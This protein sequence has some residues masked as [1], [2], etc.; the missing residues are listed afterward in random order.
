MSQ[1]TSPVQKTTDD[2][3]SN[4]G[5]VETASAGGMSRFTIVTHQPNCA[6]IWDESETCTEYPSST[7]GRHKATIYTSASAEKRGCLT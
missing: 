4:L 3:T 1:M 5:N 2:V 6:I 7:D